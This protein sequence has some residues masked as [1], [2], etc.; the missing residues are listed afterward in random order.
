M[1]FIVNIY[2]IMMNKLPL[3]HPNIID[4]KSYWGIYLWNILMLGISTNMEYG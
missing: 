4:I 2:L 3:Y 1:I